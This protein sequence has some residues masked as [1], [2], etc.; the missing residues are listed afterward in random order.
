MGTGRNPAQTKS[1]DPSSRNGP[2]DRT[3]FIHRL[4]I[5]LRTGVWG[6]LLETV[7]IHDIVEETLKKTFRSPTPGFSFSGWFLGFFEEASATDAN[8]HPEENDPGLLSDL[9]PISKA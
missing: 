9:S 6:R 4:T 3:T 8:Q 1:Y 5:S 7:Q 2:E